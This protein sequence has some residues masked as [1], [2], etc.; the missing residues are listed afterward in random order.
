MAAQVDCQEINNKLGNIQI[1]NEESLK[2]NENVL[3]HT[4]GA[5]DTPLCDLPLLDL[6]KLGLKFYKGKSF[7]LG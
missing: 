6:Y 7:L 2:N 5:S 1:T 4:D 3:K